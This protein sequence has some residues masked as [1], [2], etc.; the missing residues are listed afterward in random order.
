MKNCVAAIQYDEKTNRFQLVSG[1][2]RLEIRSTKALKKFVNDAPDISL[3]LIHSLKDQWFPEEEIAEFEEIV[4]QA[5][6]VQPRT[7]VI[8]DIDEDYEDELEDITDP[9]DEYRRVSQELSKIDYLGNAEKEIE[10]AMQKA[11]VTSVS[12]LHAKRSKTIDAEVI[13]HAM[14]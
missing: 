11:G 1:G 3:D 6:L 8:E 9:D 5:D 2:E 12:E 14:Q 4:D 13:E 7:E 10:D